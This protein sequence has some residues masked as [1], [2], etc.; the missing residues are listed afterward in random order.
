MAN[1]AH[2]GRLDGCNTWLQQRSD[3]VVFY[4]ALNATDFGSPDYAQALATQINRQLSIGGY[5]WPGL[6][7]DG[8]WVTLGAEVP[9]AGFGAYDSNY[10]GF[11]SALNRVS[12][13]SSLRLR[14]GRQ[15]WTGVINKRVFLDAPEG[16]AHLGP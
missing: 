3:G 1:A 15:N 12:D 7:S 9:S 13:G 16:L 14:A 5:T 4:L 8:F 6:T 2:S 11:Q 10:R